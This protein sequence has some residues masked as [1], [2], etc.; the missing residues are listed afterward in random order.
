MLI[1][2]DGKNLRHHAW[3]VITH[4]SPSARQSK[5]RM[6]ID[7]DGKSLSF[8]ER[9]CPEGLQAHYVPAPYLAQEA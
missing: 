5:P 1:D 6:L 8:P 4:A 7:D 9:L 3:R 2:D